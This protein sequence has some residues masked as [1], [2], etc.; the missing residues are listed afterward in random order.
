MPGR[1][2]LPCPTPPLLPCIHHYTDPPS[3][4]NPLLPD[5]WE[6][7]KKLKR[8]LRSHKLRLP[9][10]LLR[11]RGWHRHPAR[12]PS[13]RDLWRRKWTFRG[14]FRHRSYPMS[15][16]SA[17]HTHTHTHTH[18]HRFCRWLLSTIQVKKT[19]KQARQDSSIWFPQ[20]ST[21]RL[22]AMGGLWT[23]NVCMWWAVCSS[24]GIAMCSRTRAHVCVCVCVCACVCQCVCVFVCQLS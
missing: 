13:S 19:G 5:L 16:V 18:V 1:V 11:R 20:D 14:L 24:A 12:K 10:Q 15:K 9:S 21:K 7:G 8:Y 17:T 6:M 2:I 23:N 22:R 3:C 4:C